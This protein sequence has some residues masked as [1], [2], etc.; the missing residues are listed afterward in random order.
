MTLIDQKRR[1][2]LESVSKVTD[3]M[4]DGVNRGV[5]RVFA[6]QRKIEQV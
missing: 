6:N 4:V 1:E 3:S 2:V 5:A